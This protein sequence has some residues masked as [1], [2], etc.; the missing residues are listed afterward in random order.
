MLV[1]CYITVNTTIEANVQY[2]ELKRWILHLWVK[3]FKQQCSESFSLNF[4]YYHFMIICISRM[5]EWMSKTE[6]TIMRNPYLTLIELL[7][8]SHLYPVRP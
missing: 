8:D 2:E 4:N 5:S 6:K 7:V 3:Y 1:K